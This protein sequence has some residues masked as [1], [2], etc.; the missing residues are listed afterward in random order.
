M[1]LRIYDVLL[2][3]GAT[4]TLMRVA[5]SLMQRNEAKLKTFTEIDDIM[6]FLL[7]RQIW[8]S[9]ASFRSQPNLLT[10]SE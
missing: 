3:E 8:V 9:P 2:S 1:L 10:P 5:L 6:P 4:E 7:G